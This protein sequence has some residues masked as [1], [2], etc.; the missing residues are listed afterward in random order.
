MAATAAAPAAHEHHFPDKAGE[1]VRIGLILFVLTAMEVGCYELA[2][3][4]EAPG[5]AFWQA[6]LIPIL[7]VLSALK[8]MMVA[9]YYMHLKWDGRLLKGLFVFSLIIAAIV[10]VALMV[11]FIYHYKYA[12]SLGGVAGM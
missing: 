9:S 10:I 11:L 1:Y 8:F 6:W 2:H 5:H 4:A 7:I 3:R 12:A